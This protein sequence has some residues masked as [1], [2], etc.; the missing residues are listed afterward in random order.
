[1]SG[2]TRHSSPDDT[3]RADDGPPSA[4]QAAFLLLE[5]DC[6]GA[7]AGNVS[8]AVISNWLIGREL[9]EAMAHSRSIPHSVKRPLDR[10]GG[11]RRLLVPGT[12]C[13]RSRPG[14]RASVGVAL[15]RATT[16]EIALSLICT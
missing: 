9:P 13:A 1:M 7:A 16:K 6:H 15:L 11:D 12:A 2:Q 3:I 5:Q 10:R 14:D 4:G 8:A